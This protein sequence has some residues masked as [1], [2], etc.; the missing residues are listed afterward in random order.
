MHR[1]AIAETIAWLFI[2]HRRVN[3]LALH[4]AETIRLG[5]SVL[6]NTTQLLAG[7]IGALVFDYAVSKVENI[8][9]MSEVQSPASPI[10][11]ISAHNHGCQQYRAWLEAALMQFSIRQC[12]VCEAPPESGDSATS[13][14]RVHP[15][16]G[17]LPISCLE[18][19]CQ[20]KGFFEGG[21]LLLLLLNKG[22]SSR[23]KL[24]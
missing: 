19:Q 24:G 13:L 6:E 15:S 16:L 20:E 12:H 17:C 22:D 1:A 5:L 2:P 10:E 18:N 8:A 7:V 4:N 21:G 3:I 9:C 14:A 23:S 11:R